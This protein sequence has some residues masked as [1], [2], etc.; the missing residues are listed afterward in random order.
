MEIESIPTGRYR[1]RTEWRWSLVFRELGIEFK[2]EPQVFD[3]GDG[4]YYLPDFLVCGTW[5]EV[6]G[7]FQ[8][9]DERA[10]AIWKLAR[11]CEITGERGLVVVGSPWDLTAYCSPSFEESKSFTLNGIQIPGAQSRDAILEAKKA[12]FNEH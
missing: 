1:S 9:E 11:V 4:Q 10:T 8:S 3:L 5:I 7:T 2:Y 6:K 12:R